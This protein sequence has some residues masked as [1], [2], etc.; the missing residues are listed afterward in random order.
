VEEVQEGFRYYIG[1]AGQP[2]LKKIINSY[3]TNLEC[4]FGG[5][6]GRP[7]KTRD[8]IQFTQ[9]RKMKRNLIPDRN[10][11][12]MRHPHC[13]RVLECPETEYFTR[14][15]LER[16]TSSEKR[17]VFT[18]SS[19]SNRTGIRLEGEPLTFRKE[20]S[21][22]IVS[23]GILPGTIQIPGDGIPIIQL[24]ERTIGGYARV[25][26]VAKVDQYLLA[27]LQP[28]DYVLLKMIGIEEA[29]DLWRKKL[30]QINLLQ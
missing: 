4:C 23:E 27:H 29:E 1:F 7:L 15:S 26:I 5:Y 2:A 6:K 8:R 21:K 25:A 9:I 17:T 24:Y 12:R 3:A 13:L 16:I 20:A 11:P 22:S 30:E 18:V 19:R 28:D 14:E 10:I